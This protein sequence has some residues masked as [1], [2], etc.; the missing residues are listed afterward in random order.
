MAN[1]NLQGVQQ[2]RTQSLD[3][4]GKNARLSSPLSSKNLPDDR[5]LLDKNST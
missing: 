4:S 2:T 1:F 5:T 3:L